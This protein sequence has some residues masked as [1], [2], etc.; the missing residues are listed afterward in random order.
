VSPPSLLY[1]G[2]RVI[3]GCKGPGRNLDH[4]PHLE[5]RL[6]KGY[7]YTSTPPLGLRGLFEGELY[8]YLYLYTVFFN[9]FIFRI[10]V[11]FETSFP[12]SK[13]VVL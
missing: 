11:S 4:P 2:Y 10:V 12:V 7:S 3:P 8:L 5:S 1:N 9:V 6:K 13:R